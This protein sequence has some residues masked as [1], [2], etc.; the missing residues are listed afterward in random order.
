MSTRYPG[1]LCIASLL[2]YATVMP[3]AARADTDACTVLTAAQVGSAIGGSVTAGTHV[4][5]TFVRTCT[6]NASG[7]SSVKF[8]TLYL[9]T[10]AA[11][12]GGKR[13]AAEMAVAGAGVKPASGGD[14][15]YYFVAGNQVGLLVKK[16]SASFKVTV[17]ATIPLEQ[18]EAME[19]TL[20]KEALAKL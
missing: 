19:L 5:P 17:Y 9:Q 8:V 16:G 7:S 1:T 11:Y 3:S 14:D 20:A 13:M 15:A 4:T 10:A 12:D 6:W 18:K 2:L